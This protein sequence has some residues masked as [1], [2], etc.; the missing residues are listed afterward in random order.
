V[1]RDADAPP[2]RVGPDQQDH[3]HDGGRDAQAATEPRS[4][5]SSI[6]SRAWSRICRRL[7]AGSRRDILIFGLG[8]N[9][10]AEITAERWRGR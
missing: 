1:E 9:P 5:N 2:V 8:E 3:Q 6:R 7:V 4:R 10:T